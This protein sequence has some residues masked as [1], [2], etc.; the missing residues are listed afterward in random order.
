[1][2]FHLL[3]IEACQEQLYYHCDPSILCLFTVQMLFASLAHILENIPHLVETILLSS[4]MDGS[5]GSL[6]A[7]I[8]P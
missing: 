5:L 6:P 8:P 1:M 7:Y 2:N 4:A 3:A